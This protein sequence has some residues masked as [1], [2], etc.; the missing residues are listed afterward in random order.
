MKGCSSGG[1]RILP[2]ERAGYV[3]HPILRRPDQPSKNGGVTWPFLEK[4]EECRSYSKLSFDH[5]KGGGIEST[6][7][8]R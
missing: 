1:G 4:G 2:Q 6:N 8:E 7:E 5:A 3:N